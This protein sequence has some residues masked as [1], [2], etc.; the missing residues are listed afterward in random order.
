MKIYNVNYSIN[1]KGNSKYILIS[2]FHG[3]FNIKL[4]NYMSS[5]KSDYIII[6]GDIMNGSSWNK[7]KYFN[8]FKRFIDIISES[9]KVI[10]SLGNHD[11]WGIEDIGS[12][13]FKSLKSDSVYPIYNE[14]CI[15]GNDSFTSFVPDKTCYNY[16]RQDDTK[17]V[18]DILKTKIDIPSGNYIKHLISHNPYHFYHNDIMNNIG[19]KF[20]MIFVG[21]FHDGY[22]P[23]KY[24]IKRYNKMIDKG[25]QEILHKKDMKTHLKHK[26]ILARGIAYMYDDR[27]YVLLPND[28]VY[29]YEKSNKYYLSSKEEIP[30]DV[31]PIIITGAINTCFRLKMFYPYILK[32]ENGKMN[33]N[34]Y[35]KNN[36]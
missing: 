30:S 24:L 29:C 11:L 16:F 28:E 12:K 5:I 8:K 7:D 26:R 33:A 35:I 19:K 31:P 6:S 10:I 14:T 3:Y 32:L 22:I 21:H 18:S 2:D 4:A 1:Y 34:Y 15:I 36:V 23:T 20:D 25:M 17:T 27:Y 9:H 13:N